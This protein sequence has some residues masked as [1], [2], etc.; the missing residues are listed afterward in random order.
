MRLYL[1]YQ[2]FHVFDCGPKFL[3]LEMWGSIS[4]AGTGLGLL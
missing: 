1:G 2:Y 4:L 3:F